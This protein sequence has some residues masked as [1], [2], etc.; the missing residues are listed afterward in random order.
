MI[1]TCAGL[2]AH[3]ADAC[4]T[5][6]KESKIMLFFGRNISKNYL[7][8]DVPLP[9]FEMMYMLPMYDCAKISNLDSKKSAN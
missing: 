1:W 9:K 5:S 2:T 8:V 3:V 7:F 6:T 4:I